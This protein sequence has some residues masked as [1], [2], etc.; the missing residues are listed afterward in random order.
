MPKPKGQSAEP[1]PIGAWRAM[2]LGQTG[3]NG[4]RKAESA[5]ADHAQALWP[6]LPADVAANAL[7][8]RGLADPRQSEVRRR[9]G[10]IGVGR[11]RPRRNPPRQTVCA[12]FLSLSLPVRTAPGR[13]GHCARALASPL[14]AWGQTAKATEQTPYAR[15]S[16]TLKPPVKTGARSAAGTPSPAPAP[17]Y[18]HTDTRMSGHGT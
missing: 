17:G 10:G 2:A 15:A 8:P 16:Q 6:E 5:A 3:A 14:C 7:S 9:P 4:A 11:T 1:R 12:L 13:I 18:A